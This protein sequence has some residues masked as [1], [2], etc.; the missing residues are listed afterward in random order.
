MSEA[1]TSMMTLDSRRAVEN[2]THGNLREDLFGFEPAAAHVK[3]HVAQER[4]GLVIQSDDIAIGRPGTSEVHVKVDTLLAL[5][6]L[7]EVGDEDPAR[8]RPVSP[9]RDAD[10]SSFGEPIGRDATLC[11]AEGPE[12]GVRAR[13]A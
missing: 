10:E 5:T 7:V 11:S 6:V 9:Q 4:V 2:E 1:L 12:S 13:A 3:Q 8:R